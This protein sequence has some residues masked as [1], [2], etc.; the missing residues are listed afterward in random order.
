MPTPDLLVPSRYY[1]RLGDVLERHGLA[2]QS[3]LEQMQLRPDAFDA[4]DGTVRHSQVERFVAL[5]ERI[6][7]RTDLAFDLG[8]MLSLSTHSI[9][10]F[11]M[12]ASPTADDAIRFVARYFRLV[13]P[14]FKLRYVCKPDRSELHFTPTIAMGHQCLA[15]HLEA[16]ALAALRDVKD[17]TSGNPPPCRLQFSI[18]EPRHRYRYE[19]LADTQTFFSALR[20]PGIMLVV[21]TDLR[22]VRLPMSDANALN[23]AEERCR[24]K[25]NQLSGER[26]YSEWVMMTLR[27]VGNGG[28]SLNEVARQ[29][30]LS[31]RT[32]NRYLQRE[33]TSFRGLAAQVHH[34]L[35]CQRLLGGTQ[36][37]TEI[38]YSLGYTCISNFTRA[39]RGRANCSPTDFRQRG[40]S[41][42][43]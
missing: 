3:V 28:P 17:L 18:D 33:G 4:P 23:V 41:V 31:T 40:G 10:G 26:R 38:A 37:V 21:G 27:E 14:S 32:L 29:L 11:G 34:E 25:L 30:N 9:V 13:M 24:S 43:R 19:S 12:L 15:F 5:V 16:I 35:A 39:F 2:L 6:S 1:K 36:S 8:P 22:S 7:G 20:E 42:P